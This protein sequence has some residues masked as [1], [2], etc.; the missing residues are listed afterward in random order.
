MSLLLRMA[1]HLFILLMICVGNR[2]GNH[3]AMEVIQDL[4]LVDYILVPIGGGG[5]ATGVST[6]GQDAE[7]QYQGHRC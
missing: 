2:S 6:L 1:T 4:P 3:Q 5:L 7:E